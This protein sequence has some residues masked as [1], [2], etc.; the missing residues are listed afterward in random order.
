ML[1]KI[2]DEDVNR[3]LDSMDL[4]EEG[5]PQK[6]LTEDDYKK[7]TEWQEFDDKGNLKIDAG[8]FWEEYEGD[9]K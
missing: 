4:R 7:H 1:D 6:M 5:T 2:S 8:T 3:T 9:D